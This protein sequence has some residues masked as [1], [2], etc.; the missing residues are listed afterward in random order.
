MSSLD[1]PEVVRREY[2]SEAGLQARRAAYRHADGPN[3]P[4]MAFQAV[5]E[6]APGRVLEVGCGP[7]ELA[8]RIASEVGADVKALDIS[9]RMVELAL[10][11]GIDAVVGDAQELPYPDGSFDCAVA[12]WM[13][14]HV[15]DVDRALAELARVLR[16]GGRL[17]AVT[18]YSDHLKELRDLIRVSPSI[19]AFRGE[20]A[21]NLL[22]R[23]F[24]RVEV[25]DAGGTVTFPDREAVVA[26]VRNLVIHADRADRVPQLAGPLVVRRRPVVLVATK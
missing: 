1:D 17:V 19:S 15:P 6:V 16:E 14:Y 13:L 2:A 25:R 4:E 21:A 7:G 10:G 12:A 20:D 3:A 11:R 24:A 26:F 23:H 22:S 9:P 8:E 18:N 5:A